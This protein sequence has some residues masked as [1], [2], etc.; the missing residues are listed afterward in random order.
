[1]TRPPS[2]RKK[3]PQR[4]VQSY[5]DAVGAGVQALAAR[6]FDGVPKESVQ[7]SKSRFLVLVLNEMVLVLV[8]VLDSPAVRSSMSTGCA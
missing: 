5:K 3:W 4:F 8:L 6:A 2:A 7:L 1:M